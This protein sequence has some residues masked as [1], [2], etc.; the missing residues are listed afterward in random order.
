MTDAHLSTNVY[1]DKKPEHIASLFDRVAARYDLSNALLT[2]G[3]DQVWLRALRNAVGPQVGEKILDVA[4]GTGASSAILADSGARVIGCDISE[5]MIEVGR[6]RHPEIEFVIGNAMALDFE[7]DTFDA[8][9][10]CWGLRNIPETDTALKEMLRVTKPGGRLVVCEFSTPPNAAF[11]GLYRAHMETV[12]PAIARVFSSD[13]DA[14]DYL[15]E[16]IL[17]W[18]DQETLGRIIHE[19][20]WDDVEYRNLTGGIAALHRAIKPLV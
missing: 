18:P 4:A 13:P 17:A 12:M 14:Y 11:R 10:I 16:S 5:G 15:V 3:M 8:V 19:A 7:D 9:T 6:Q 2:G 1:L 20:G